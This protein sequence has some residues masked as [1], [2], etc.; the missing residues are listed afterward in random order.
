MSNQQDTTKPVEIERL[1]DDLTKGL[2]RCQFLLRSCRA[3]LAANSN[4]PVG[5][6]AEPGQRR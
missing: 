4:Q 2:E 1:S 3:K 6:E 5:S